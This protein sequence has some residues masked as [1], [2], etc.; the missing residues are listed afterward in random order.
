MGQMTA[1]FHPIMIT[2][3]LPH[4]SKYSPFQR[5]LRLSNL[6]AEVRPDHLTHI[7]AH[8]ASHGGLTGAPREPGVSL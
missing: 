3:P 7:L 6:P 1:V 5:A 2:R 8:P 4:K